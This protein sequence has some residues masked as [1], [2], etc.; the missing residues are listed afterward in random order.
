MTLDEFRHEMEAYW[1]SVDA[2][3]NDFKDPFIATKRMYDLYQRFDSD[4][5][6]MADQVLS[7]WALLEDSSMQF[8]ALAL[9][10]DFE[11][12]KAIGALQRLATHVAS[13]R[14][15]G[16]RHKLEKVNRIIDKL[17]KS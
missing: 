11:I 2:E 5:R 14:A 10:E 13:S 6:S 17:A 9:I 1:Q 4:E 15:P 3:A 12:K 16:A 7:E 8:D